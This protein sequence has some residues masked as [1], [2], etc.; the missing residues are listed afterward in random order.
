M[1]F[2]LVLHS[3]Q[4]KWY[5]DQQLGTVMAIWTQYVATKY[6]YYRFLRATNS[7]SIKESYLMGQ[8]GLFCH[9][10][11]V[12]S[13][14][15]HYNFYNNYMWKM[16]IQYIVPGFKP[17][18]F[19]TWVSSHNHFTRAPRFLLRLYFICHPIHELFGAYIVFPLCIPNEWHQSHW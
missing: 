18:T 12:F 9:L 14:K 5:S 10:F 11:L 1:W 3:F 2:E 19:G 17:T 7:G 13:N 15:H 4:S 16:S 8:P 6:V